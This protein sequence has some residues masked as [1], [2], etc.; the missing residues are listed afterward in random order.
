MRRSRLGLVSALVLTAACSSESDPGSD[1]AAGTTSTANGSGGGGGAGGAPTGDIDGEVRRYEYAF[2]LETGV[3][4]SRL[5]ID[6]AHAGGDCFAVSCAL[7]ELANATFAGEPAT[8]S[9]IDAGEVHLCGAAVAPGT[10]FEITSEATVPEKTFIGLDVGFSRTVDLAGGTFTYLMS[11]VG[12]CDHFGPCD[13]DPS[14]LAEF[15]FDVT[16]P[17]GT[18][19]LCPGALT[20]GDTLTSCEIAGTLAP[21]Y[22]AFAVAA[23]P[24]WVKAPF[25]TTGGV[26]LVFYEVPG[27]TLAANLE[28]PSVTAFFEWLTGVVGAYPYGSELRFAGGPTEWLG[29]EH[30]GNVILQEELPSVAGAYLNPTMHVFMHEVVHQW[31]GDKVTLASTLDFVWKEATA[32]YLSY[33]FEDEQRPVGEAASTLAYWDDVSL[34][35]EHYP[36]PMDEPAPSVQSFYGDVYG[37]GPMVLYV[38]LESIFGR[39]VV[40]EAIGAFLALPGA[41]SVADLRDALEQASGED[42]DAYFDAWVFGTGEPEWPTMTIG[43]S[44][45]GDQVTVT[46]TQANPSGKLYGCAIDVLVEGATQSVTARVD[47]GLAPSSAVA[48]ATVNLG[49]PVVGTVLDP[50]HR[51]IAREPGAAPPARRPVW[52]F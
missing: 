9:Q 8:S 42:L 33:V 50:D 3:G 40:L 13:D 51:V 49:E 43:T 12:G 48:T 14:K 35:S 7:A 25:L 2:D 39:A 4:R 10:G 1:A 44:Q 29:F 20:A 28:K 32:E 6:A 27:G 21:T 36:R 15:R 11:W 37:P 26:D 38:Q 23:D 19:V 30:P 18:T 34:F 22:S 52:I 31:A 24:L 16:H 45:V 17:A 46:V 47:F 5:S 41:R